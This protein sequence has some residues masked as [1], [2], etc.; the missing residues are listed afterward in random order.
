[1]LEGLRSECSKSTVLRIVPKM[2][3]QV[4]F[5]FT[6]QSPRS[7]FRVVS[8]AKRPRLASG[9]I[10]FRVSCQPSEHQTMVF[11]TGALIIKIG[12]WAHDTKMIIRS[13]QNNIGNHLGPLQ[14]PVYWPPAGSSLRGPQ[15]TTMLCDGPR[16]A[17]PSTTRQYRLQLRV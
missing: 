15:P 11:N 10:L 14:L 7:S 12:L 2:Q 16:A 4:V 17:H 8:R 13:P 1:M 6:I 3:V 5:L 9:I